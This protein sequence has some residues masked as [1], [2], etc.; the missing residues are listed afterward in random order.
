M[1]ASVT[2]SGGADSIFTRRT[3]R[4]MDL[5]ISAMLLVV[6]S[7]LF[8]V[9]ALLVAM[10]GGSILFAHERVGR[11]RKPFSCLKF[12][13]MVVGASAALDE[14]LALDPIATQEWRLNQKL[15]SDPRV[16]GVG[17]LLRM[18]SLDE[19]PQLVNVL[20]GNMSLVGPRPVTLLE[21]QRYGDDTGY[22]LAIRPGI[23]G[24]W[25]VSGRNGVSYSERVSLDTQYVKTQSIGRDLIILCKTL[26]VVMK[27]N[28]K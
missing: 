8:A 26:G 15:D 2:S 14:Y 6:L 19:L 12:R 20:L 22:Y 9:I 3:K 11:N 27:C 10:D 23:T 5:A 21:L 28:G 1:S 4:S 24:L 16:T 13:T 17:R 7:P 18:A 25:Q